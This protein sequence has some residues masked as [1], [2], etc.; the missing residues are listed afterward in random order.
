[1]C[2]PLA[3]V[4]KSTA[5]VSQPPSAPRLRPAIAKFADVPYLELPPHSDVPS[6]FLNTTGIHS[7]GNPVLQEDFMGRT[8]RET[9]HATDSEQLDDQCMMFVCRLILQYVRLAD[10]VYSHA[11]IASMS[12]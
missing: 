2:Q 10:D 7:V 6:I 12:T 4:V 3:D 9:P 1:M 8:P 5:E 11:E